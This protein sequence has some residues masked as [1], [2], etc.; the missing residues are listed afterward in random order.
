MKLGRMLALA[1]L[2]ALAYRQYK[3]MSPEDKKAIDDKIDNA[4]RNLSNLGTDLKSKAQETINKVETAAKDLQT[5][6]KDKLTSVN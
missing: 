5:E 6:A 1:G 2:G 4:K 3:K